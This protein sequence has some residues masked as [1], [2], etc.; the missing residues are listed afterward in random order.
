MADG[1]SEEDIRRAEREAEKQKR[2]NEMMGEGKFFDGNKLDP[3]GLKHIL[4][5]HAPD[6]DAAEDGVFDSPW[7]GTDTFYRFTEDYV[8]PEKRLQYKMEL[9]AAWPGKKS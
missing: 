6:N 2:T 5:K 7:T 9:E 4:D 3:A 8:A 1:P